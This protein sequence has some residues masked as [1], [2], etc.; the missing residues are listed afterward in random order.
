MK[1]ISLRKIFLCAKTSLIKWLLDPKMIIFAA[2]MIFAYNYVAVPLIGL[3]EELGVSLNVFES[4]IA[5][6]NSGMIL[7]ILPRG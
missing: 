6:G 5:L 4:F 1:D 2:A 7:L 3:S